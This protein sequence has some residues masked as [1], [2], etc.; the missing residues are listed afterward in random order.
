M[1]MFFCLFV[2]S[3][4]SL[5]HAAPIID[6]S[7]DNSSQYGDKLYEFQKNDILNQVYGGKYATEW[8]QCDEGKT[9][10]ESEIQMVR[11]SFSN[12]GADEM[13]LTFASNECP[14][15]HA[16]RHGTIVLV[17]DGKVID[18]RNDLMST[19]VEK[20]LDVD[21]DGASEMIVSLSDGNQGYFN[22]LAESVRFTN[23]RIQSFG[24]V[25]GV[26]NTTSCAAFSDESEGEEIAAVF[27]PSKTGGKPLQKNYRKSCVEGAQYEFHSDGPLEGH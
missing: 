20:I 14:A 11:G 7:E 18:A 9:L 13:V 24:Y 1:K 17:R 22:T 25:D 3:L 4:T 26:V 8:D 6:F 2:L 5:A 10:I 19:Q 15:S 27:F 16:G 23:G 21:G 12:P